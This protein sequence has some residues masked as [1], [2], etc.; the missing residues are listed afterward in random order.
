MITA[1][2]EERAIK[3]VNSSSNI[4][5]G[6]QKSDKAKIIADAIVDTAKKKYPDLCKDENGTAV[7]VSKVLGSV[8]V[9][10]EAILLAKQRHP[11]IKL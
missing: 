10:H 5:T 4:E 2:N 8:F 3:Q 11:E 1:Y 7:A 6:E 9:F